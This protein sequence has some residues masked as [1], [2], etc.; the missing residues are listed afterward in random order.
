M[1]ICFFIADFSPENTT[2]TSSL[3]ANNIALVNRTFNITCRT[4][5][6]PPAEFRFYRDEI[7][8]FNATT[9]SNVAVFTASVSERRGPVSFYCIPFNEYGD[10]PTATI[11]VTVYC[12]F[13]IQS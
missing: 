7:S 11:R 8:L 6:N 10:G 2:L 9:G 12:K 4:E 5:A 3:T 1:V 13:V